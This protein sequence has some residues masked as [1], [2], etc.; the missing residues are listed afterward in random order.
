[1]AWD[2]AGGDFSR[3]SKQEIRRMVYA[4]LREVRAAA[5]PFPIEGR[6]PNFRGA[7]EAAR[8]LVGLPEWVEARIVKVNPDSPQRPVR[9]LAL[10]QG[11]LLVMP[12]PRIRSGFLILDPARI[13]S[14]RYREASTIR[15]AFRY[16]RRLSTLDEVE[17]ELDRVD[18]IV[19]GSVAVSI[20]GDRIGKGEGYGDLEYAILRELGVVDENTP[21]ATTVHPVQVFRTR[22]PQDPHD[23]PVD[24][25]VTPP[26][27]GHR[28][29]NMPS[30]VIRAERRERPPGIL[31]DLLSDEKLKEIPLLRELARRR[32]RL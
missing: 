13:P 5:P 14:S 7:A 26:S 19:E 4:R 11:K 12:T 9:L 18:F 10:M 22:L 29:S 31:W 23:V 6:I 15:G 17:A 28:T 1:M 3:Y 27:R 2:D 21:I 25:I 20:Y 30:G 24:Y 8:L 16:G 32:G